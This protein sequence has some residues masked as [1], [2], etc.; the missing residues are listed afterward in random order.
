MDKLVTQG[1]Q[2]GAS[3]ALEL[4]LSERSQLMQVLPPYHVPFVS[5][6]KFNEAQLNVFWYM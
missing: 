5:Y 6:E 3:R 1:L 2:P 4:R